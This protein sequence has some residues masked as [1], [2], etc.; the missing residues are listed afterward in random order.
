M[1]PARGSPSR[2]GSARE[3]PEAQGHRLRGDPPSRGVGQA[4]PVHLAPKPKTT[5]GCGHRPLPLP[6]RGP[7]VLE[8]QPPSTHTGLHVPTC[9][10]AEL[11][12]AL[13][14]RPRDRQQPQIACPWPLALSTPFIQARR[15]VFGSCPQAAFFTDSPGSPA[16][17]SDSGMRAGPASLTEAAVLG[18]Q[19]GSAVMPLPREG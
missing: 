10:G 4:C 12:M 2:E 7:H 18:G 14:T 8:E 11:F 13:E 9:Q 15:P 5:R 19:R 3:G 6:P 17:T 1:S 16:P